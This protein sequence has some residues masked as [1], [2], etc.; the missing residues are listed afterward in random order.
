MPVGDGNDRAARQVH[1][2]ASSASGR[3]RYESEGN[4]DDDREVIDVIR[5]GEDAD[6]AAFDEQRAHPPA[7]L[8]A[9][10]GYRAHRHGEAERATRMVK[11]LLDFTQLRS[12]HGMPIERRSANL[13]QICRQAVD[14]AALANPNRILV[15]E[16]T[17][18]GQG[19][20]DSDRLAQ[21][22]SNLTRNWRPL[23]R[24]CREGQGLGAL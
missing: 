18:E 20:W 21:V 5:I 17:G 10:A 22:V 7:E 14:E 2:A 23:P 15:H 8:E 4:A 19:S 11:D 9:G 24:P 6:V 13:H 16:A 12:S 3:S 1:R